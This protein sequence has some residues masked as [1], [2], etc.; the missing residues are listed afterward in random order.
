MS[1]RK[2]RPDVAERLADRLTDN[3]HTGQKR[4]QPLEVHGSVNEH[5]RGAFTANLLICGAEPH[6]GAV[7][8][9]HA[10]VKVRRGRVPIRASARECR[11][12]KQQDGTSNPRSRPECSSV[13][14]FHRLFPPVANSRL[15][16]LTLHRWRGGRP[17]G[18]V[19]GPPS[20]ERAQRFWNLT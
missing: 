19:R 7:Y 17:S 15:D 5:A 16:T 9:G 14:M 12:A 11:K 6:R 4:K 8:L 2:R 10:I 3:L 13:A 18:G 20:P 1:W